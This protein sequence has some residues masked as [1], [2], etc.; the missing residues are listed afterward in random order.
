MQLGY[1]LFSDPAQPKLTSVM[2]LTMAYLSI[3]LLILFGFNLTTAV[4]S[5][6]NVPVMSLDQKV[7]GCCSNNKLK[8]CY[9]LI[10]NEF[11]QP[12]LKIGSRWFIIKDIPRCL[13]SIKFK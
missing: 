13:V 12:Y 6:Y 2:Q 1:F 5:N 8:N 10:F 3:P 11:F 9:L 4:T 7:Q